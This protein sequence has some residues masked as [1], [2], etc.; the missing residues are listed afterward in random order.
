MVWAL[1]SVIGLAALCLVGW[2]AWFVWDEERYR[3]ARW[4]PRPGAPLH[5]VSGSGP[6]TEQTAVIRR[7]VEVKRHQ[8]TAALEAALAMLEVSRSFR[9]DQP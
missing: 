6:E 7:A 8:D 1:G 3:K 9:D 4:L 5:S 2:V